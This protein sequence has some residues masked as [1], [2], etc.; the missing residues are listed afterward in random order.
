MQETILC[1]LL[2]YL[3]IWNLRSLTPGLILG[4]FKEQRSA[5]S[6]QTQSFE[7]KGLTFFTDQH[8]DFASGPA[9]PI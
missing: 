2:M 1:F 8:M 4:I 7:W 9:C 6:I 3:E 5:I